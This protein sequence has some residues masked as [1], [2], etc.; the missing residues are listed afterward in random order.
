MGGRKIRYALIGMAPYF[1]HSDLSMT[2][3]ESF[4]L[5]HYA[6]ALK[7]LNNFWLPYEKYCNL[8]NENYLSYKLPLN[9]FDINNI[10]LLKTPLRF[11]DFKSRMGARERT[12]PWKNKNYPDTLK[13]YVKIFDDYLSLCRK[14]KV[15]PI[16]LLFPVSKC[17]LKYFS[18][19]I[20]AEFHHFVNEA[21]KKYPEAVFIDGWQVQGFDDSDFIDV[22]HMNIKGAAKFSALLNNVILQL[23]KS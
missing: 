3:S 2:Y 9:D 8:F 1:F 15:R 21:V 23:E 12:E 18:K 20:L 6:I 7:D 4:R 5:L 19:K 22:D 11:M 13:E 17:Y 16:M 10:M 14:N